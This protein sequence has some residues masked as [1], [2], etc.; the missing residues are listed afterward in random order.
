MSKKIVRKPKIKRH[1]EKYN[2]EWKKV[3]LGIEVRES[4]RDEF[5]EA[6][7]E[8]NDTMTEVLADYMEYYIR[9]TKKHK[10]KAESSEE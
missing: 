6:V 5:R 7:E 3:R 9:E 4:L 10:R 8:N 2:L 1:E